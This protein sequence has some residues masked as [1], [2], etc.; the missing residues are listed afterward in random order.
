MIIYFSNLV[1]ILLSSFLNKTKKFPIKKLLFVLTITQ[2]IFILGL[3]SPYVGADTLSYVSHFERGLNFSFFDFSYSRF[4][5]GFLLLNKVIGL[6]ASTQTYL[7]IVGMI[8]ISLIGWVIYT[9]SE[10]PFFSLFLFISLGFYT[11]TFNLV[12]QM[13]AVALIFCSYKFLKQDKFISFTLLIFLAATF[14]ITALLFFPIYLVRYRKISSIYLLISGLLSII[15]AILAE[16]LLLFMVVYFG[17]FDYELIAGGGWRRLVLLIFILATSILY[18]K[19]IIQNDEKKAIY[20]NITV[21]AIFIQILALNFSLFTR[22]TAYFRI[23]LLLFI[24]EII[25]NID[26]KF[27]RVLV[28]IAVV[29]FL[30]VQYSVS[31]NNDISN[32]VPY[33]FFWQE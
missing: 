9:E 10:M 18:R 21:F 26:D 31:L 32:I 3:R 7:F 11:N 16:N 4:E 14:H 30:L 33:T 1:S 6:F 2:M 8:S 19:K 29:V 25:S 13:I 28:I 17:S 20:F 24:P 15:V 22:V 27:V 23:Y 12:R 5:P